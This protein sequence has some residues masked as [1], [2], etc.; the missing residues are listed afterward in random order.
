MGNFKQ[1]LTTSTATGIAYGLAGAA[2]GLP[3][4]SCAIAAGS[5][6]VAGLLPDI[7]SSSSRSF[8]EC[9]YV[10][11]GITAMLCINRLKEFPINPEVITLAGAFIFLFV[12]FGVGSAIKKMTVHRGMY[13]SIPAAIIAGE[14]TFLVSTGSVEIRI[15]KAV[16]LVCGFLSHLLLDEIF[17]IDLQGKRIKKSFGT[18][19]KMFNFKN[20]P[21]TIFTYATL[22]V[23]LII[24]TQEPGI[25]QPFVLPT[26]H[27]SPEYAWAESQEA[28]SESKGAVK[29]PLWEQLRALVIQDTSPKTDTVSSPQSPAS[30]TVPEASRVVQNTPTA[31]QPSSSNIR[32]R[33]LWQPEKSPAIP[34]DP[35]PATMVPLR[36]SAIPQGGIYAQFDE[37]PH[38]PDVR[39]MTAITSLPMEQEE[40]PPVL[41]VPIGSVPLLPQRPAF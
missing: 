5:C 9:I 16:G 41:S 36:Q 19:I 40:S 28:E 35:E 26:V 39:P 21:A 11:A 24:A 4:T 31:Q 38:S 7:D 23:L 32:E 3:P 20:V 18:A 27:E 15:F 25:T 22:V 6:S 14:I 2:Y 37:T 10:A 17:S 34:N 13:H 30:P 1:H 33:L 12:R 8:Q 29:R